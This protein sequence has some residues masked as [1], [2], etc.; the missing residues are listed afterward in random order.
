MSYVREAS[1]YNIAVQPR[2]EALISILS[3]MPDDDAEM[4]I[5]R[6]LK[7][8]GAFVLW[9]PE[10]SGEGFLL[11]GDEPEALAKEALEY[12]DLIPAGEQ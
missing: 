1:C 9:D 6:A 11:V 4:L 8:E 12:F 3:D 2:K 7:Q 10:D 5:F